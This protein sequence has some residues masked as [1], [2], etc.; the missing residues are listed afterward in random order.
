MRVLVIILTFL[1]AQI[2]HAEGTDVVFSDYDDSLTLSG[3]NPYGAHIFEGPIRVQGNLRFKFDMGSDGKPVDIMFAHFSPDDN[4]LT[5]LPN[6]VSGPLVG[7]A[8]MISLEPASKALEMAFGKKKASELKNGTE[9]TLEIP[10]S[11]EINK[12]LTGGQ[13]DSR[14]YWTTKF[15]VSRL[16]RAVFKI[17]RNTHGC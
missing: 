12:L 11:V 8:D 7:D 15:S 2:G 5:R 6:V 9:L 1:A 17:A 3:T 10:V 13:C 14:A 4:S 16:D